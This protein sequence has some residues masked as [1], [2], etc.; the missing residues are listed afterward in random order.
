MFV[1]SIRSYL[2]WKNRI[3]N[4][5]LIK[6]V[7]LVQISGLKFQVTELQGIE[8]HYLWGGLSTADNRIPDK[9]VVFARQ[10]AWGQ[11]DIGLGSAVWQ[12]HQGQKLFLSTIL[13]VWLFNHMLVTSWMQMAAKIAD[14]GSICLQGRQACLTTEAQNNSKPV[15]LDTQG[16]EMGW[17]NVCWAF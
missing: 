2:M 3:S 10:E 17:K 15:S 6:V 8:T 16:Y 5:G 9:T 1:P 4:I 13:S 11:L 7:T 14:I 12:C